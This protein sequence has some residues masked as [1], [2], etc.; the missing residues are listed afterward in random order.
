ML[1][2]RLHSSLLQERFASLM[3]I[4]FAKVK[5]TPTELKF[6]EDGVSITGTL[7][8]EWRDSV[9][10]LSTFKADVDVICSRCG[11]EYIKHVEYPLELILSDG[12]YNNNDEI[13]VI[14]FFDGNIDITY[15]SESEIASI[16]EDYNFCED[17]ALTEEVLEVEL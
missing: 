11:K 16:Q 14:E 3:T 7:A 5:H 17:C 2:K 4:A 13:D 1:Q 15:I 9:K 8:K 12:R 6:S 10:L